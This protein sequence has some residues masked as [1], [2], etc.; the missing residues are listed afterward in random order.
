M[1]RV[2]NNSKAGISE[3]TLEQLD[4]LIN[5]DIGNSGIGQSHILQPQPVYNAGTGEKVIE[6]GTSFIVLGRDRPT[7][8]SSGYGG[9]GNTHCGTID[10]VAGLGGMLA[11]EVSETGEGVATNKSPQLDAARIYIS[12]R[13]NIDENF[14]L[15][16]GSVGN[17]GARSG[18]AV[19]ADNVRIIG[20][21]GI[22]L[23][24]SSDVYNSQGI[25]VNGTIAGID[26]IAGNDTKVYKLEPLVKGDALVAAFGELAELMG[27][28]N[29][30]C[31]GLLESVID[32]HKDFST[33]IHMTSTGPT[34]PSPTGL[35]GGALATIQYALDYLDFFA[36]GKNIK[37]WELNHLRPYGKGFINSNFNKTN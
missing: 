32:L 26:L 8:L 3:A 27:D 10:I 14:G 12:Q 17:L 15:T 37:T 16:E 4:S 9:A 34:T 20:R 18:I 2:I 19:K 13:T 11:R 28:L 5:P 23:V 33:H 35:A 1:A 30:N 21:E 36:T 31:T 22:K 6:Q 24:T 7:D 25:N 29:E